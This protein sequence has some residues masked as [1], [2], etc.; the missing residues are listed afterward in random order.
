MRERRGTTPLAALTR[1]RSLQAV[2]GLP[3]RFYWAS[4]L[5]FRR[6]PGD[7]RIDAVSAILLVRVEAV[8]PA[9]RGIGQFGCC[10]T[11]DPMAMTGLD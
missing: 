10:R 11:A 1:G 5:F 8:L 9:G 7:G 2:T 6:L 4:W 3:A